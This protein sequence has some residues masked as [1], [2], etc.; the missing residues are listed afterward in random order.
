M[1]RRGVRLTIKS[2]ERDEGYVHLADIEDV[3]RAGYQDDRMYEW[4]QSD[5]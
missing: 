2:Q 3:R 5:G 4:I 1:E